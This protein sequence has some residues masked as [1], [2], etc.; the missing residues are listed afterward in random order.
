MNG[1]YLLICAWFAGFSCHTITNDA[2]FIYIHQNVNKFVKWHN[3][4]V[5]SIA[6]TIFL[7]IYF[8][9]FLLIPIGNYNRRNLDKNDRNTHKTATV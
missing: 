6:T 2:Y 1:I 7:F 9:L 3:G 5:T 8:F 4:E